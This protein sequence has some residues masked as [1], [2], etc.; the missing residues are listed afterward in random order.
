ME[1]K[2]IALIF[3]CSTGIIN[4][5]SLMLKSLKYIT[6]N[7]IDFTKGFVSIVLNIIEGG[8]IGGFVY[9]WRSFV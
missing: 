3:V 7:R 6:N 2:Y 1:W 8:L 9:I 5:S 4:Y